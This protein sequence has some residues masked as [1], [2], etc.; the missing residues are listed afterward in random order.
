MRAFRVAARSRAWVELR[1][2]LPV[3]GLQPQSLSR[4]E[5]DFPGLARRFAHEESRHRPGLLRVRRRAR[6][7]HGKALRQML[8]P[9]NRNITEVR[10]A[11]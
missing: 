2:L 6:E 9:N 4:H 5:Q 7:R 8:H 10:S 1:H 11:Y 3:N